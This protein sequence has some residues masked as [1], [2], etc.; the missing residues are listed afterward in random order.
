MVL[1]PAGNSDD[2]GY[3]E[4][5]LRVTVLVMVLMRLRVIMVLLV[6]EKVLM[7]ALMKSS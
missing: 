3:G 4:A 5:N 2:G 7:K 6:L 1:G